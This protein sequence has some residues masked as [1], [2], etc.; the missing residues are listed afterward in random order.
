MMWYHQHVHRDKINSSEVDGCHLVSQFNRSTLSASPTGWCILRPTFSFDK[1]W[2]C[3]HLPSTHFR[4]KS[5]VEPQHKE[6]SEHLKGY[7]ML[8][9]SP[10]AKKNSQTSAKKMWKASDPVTL[11][12][13]VRQQKDQVPKSKGLRKIGR[14]LSGAMKRG[15]EDAGQAA[16]W[17]TEI[18]SLRMIGKKMVKQQ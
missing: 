13:M 9:S 15:H 6:N 2:S 12:Q 1:R 5:Y 10:S 18:P 16:G 8:E 17:A 11:F 14:R 7:R 4:S 3:W